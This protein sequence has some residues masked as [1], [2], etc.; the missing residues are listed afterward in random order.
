MTDGIDGS[1]WR[2]LYEYNTQSMSH[3]ACFLSFLT[4]LCSTRHPVEQAQ[5]SKKGIFSSA[6]HLLLE[7]EDNYEYRFF[8]AFGPIIRPNLRVLLDA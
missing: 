3:D 7:R 4:S 2:R 5:G 8:N 1:L 6:D